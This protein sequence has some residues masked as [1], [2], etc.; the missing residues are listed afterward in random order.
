MIEEAI[1]F[2]RYRPKFRQERRI[3]FSRHSVGTILSSYRTHASFDR[4]IPYDKQRKKK[5]N[6]GAKIR[7]ETRLLAAKF[8]GNAKPGKKNEQLAIYS[9]P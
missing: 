5:K 7:E 8:H 6:K 4:I 2:S 9:R 1:K 3:F